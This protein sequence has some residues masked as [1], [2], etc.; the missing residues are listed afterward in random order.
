MEEAVQYRESTNGAHK[1]FK[2]NGSETKLKNARLSKD[3]FLSFK[4][5]GIELLSPMGMPCRQ[6]KM[7]STHIDILSSRGIG[8]EIAVWSLEILLTRFWELFARLDTGSFGLFV[9][10]GQHPSQHS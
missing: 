4:R 6:Y 9:W 3:T 10:K 5:N 1:S 2:L 8:I 7:R